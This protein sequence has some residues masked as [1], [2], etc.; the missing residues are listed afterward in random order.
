MRRMHLVTALAVVALGAPMTMF[1]ASP[2]R[3]TT[4]S[5]G[6]AEVAGSSTTPH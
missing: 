6:A 1:T 3:T 5:Q 4:A 2:L